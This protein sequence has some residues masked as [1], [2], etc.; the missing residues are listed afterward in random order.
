M[1]K[2]GKWSAV[3]GMVFVVVLMV[4]AV[5][6]AQTTGRI[7]VTGWLLGT[8][9]T[10]ESGFLGNYAIVTEEGTIQKIGNVMGDPNYLQATFKSDSGN[11]W[12]VF[13]GPKWFL[14]NQRMKL[15]VDDKVEVRGMK[16]GAAIIA[17]EIS[18]DDL[19]M[20]LRNEEDGFPSW[21]CCF[22]RK[23]K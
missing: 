23:A 8:S 10:S 13:L 1:K 11:T 9:I 7:G 14:E 4:S 2:I 16:F 3:I 12:T 19:T 20:R 15:A 17:S 22:P 5:S 18:K 21:D 6:F